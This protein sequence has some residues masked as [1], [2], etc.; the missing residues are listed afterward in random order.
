MTDELKPENC[1]F[2]G[3]AMV[4]REDC[5]QHPGT[6]TDDD[7]L[8]SGM[9]YYWNHL[10][11][12]NTRT[13]S[14]SAETIEACVKVAESYPV[15]HNN[16]YDS[17]Y[18][19]GYDAARD[20]IAE[21][22]RAQPKPVVRY[23]RTTELPASDLVERAREFAAQAF[24]RMHDEHHD[25]ESHYAKSIL[26]MAAMVRSGKDDG[27]NPVFYAALIATTAL[28]AKQPPN[29][30]LVE[31]LEFVRDI[32]KPMVGEQPETNWLSWYTTASQM[33]EAAET[34]LSTYKGEG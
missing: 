16:P 11:R 26:P 31:A 13:P 23:S 7:C 6:V 18:L 34:A 27:D 25:K 32:E 15:P 9:G 20:D 5:F 1:P 24:E 29:A 30:G 19:G 3:V 2:C 8:L 17:T 4:P 21:A 14:H 33:V 28:Q 10:E 12:W 22:I